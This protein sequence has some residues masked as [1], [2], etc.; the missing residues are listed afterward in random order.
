MSSGR[1]HSTGFGYIGFGNSQA[2]FNQRSS[3]PFSKYKEKLDLEAHLHYKMDFLHKDLTK[4]DKQKIKDK[5]R[6]QELKL[7][8]KTAF[9]SI[10]ILMIVAAIAYYLITKILSH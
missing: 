2:T 7:L 10:I 4:E 5:I 3:T 1:R 9:I 8:K 6:Q